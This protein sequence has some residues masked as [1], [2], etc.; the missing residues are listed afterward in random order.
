M[1][2]G[3]PDPSG[4]AGTKDFGNSPQ[5]RGYRAP[6]IETALVINVNTEEYTV[7]AYCEGSGRKYIDIP[8]MQPYAHYLNGEGIYF[9]PETGAPCWVCAPSDSNTPFVLGFGSAY[10]I[11]GKYKNLKRSLNAGDIFLGTRDDNFVILRRGGVLQLGAGPLNQRMH[12]PLGNWIKDVCE[13]YRLDTVGGEMVWEVHRTEEDDDADR[14]VS[15]S[16][17]SRQRANEQL[18]TC[19]LTMGNHDDDENVLMRLVVLSSGDGTGSEVIA[20]NVGKDGKVSWTCSDTFD[21]LATGD[22]SLVSDAG[23]VVIQGKTGINLKSE[24]NI[25]L[26]VANGL[27]IY[28]GRDALTSPVALGDACAQD[29]GTIAAALATLFAALNP[30][31]GGALVNPYTVPSTVTATKVFAE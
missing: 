5:R 29:F 4:N 27:M 9:M 3:L 21:L 19:Y 7:D 24:A 10:D 13:N 14:A 11:D 16:L 18:A 6:V 25:V 2:A 15:F 17:S 30:L 23:N 22:I 26:D 1:G 20:L 12:I 8:F 31:A 28:L